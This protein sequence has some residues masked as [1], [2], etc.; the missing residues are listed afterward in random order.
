VLKP[1][2]EGEGSRLDDFALAIAVCA[3]GYDLTLVTNNKAHFG[4]VRGLRL[5]NWATVT[6]R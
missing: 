4:G 2:L 6:P 1:Q 5:E 3:L